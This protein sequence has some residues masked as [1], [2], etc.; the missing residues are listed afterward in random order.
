M[1]GTR[2][3]PGPPSDHFI[4][5]EAAFAACVEQAKASGAVGRFTFGIAPVPPEI[6]HGCIRQGE[7]LPGAGSH[8]VARFVEKPPLEQAQAGQG[9]ASSKNDMF[10][11][12]ASVAW[13][14]PGASPGHGDGLTRRPGWARARQRLC[15]A[16]YGGLCGGPPDSVDDAMPEKTDIAS[17]HP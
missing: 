15:Q 11:V 12:K 3:C 17:V 8:A 2:S 9:G 13:P 5:D 10:L 6:G 1:P 7:T 14:D 4:P 16:S